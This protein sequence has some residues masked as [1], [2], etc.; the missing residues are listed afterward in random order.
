VSFVVADYACFACIT[1][2]AY[3]DEELGI[4]EVLLK[5]L[6]SEKIIRHAHQ[7]LNRRR[8]SAAH[9]RGFGHRGVEVSR[10]PFFC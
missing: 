3:S 5:N 9:L 7:T 8:L 4:E 10:T 2:E 1:D 6:A